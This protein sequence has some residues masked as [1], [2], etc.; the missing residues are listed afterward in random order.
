M[1]YTVDKLLA[2]MRDGMVTYSWCSLWLACMVTDENIDETMRKARS[3]ADEG[4]IT[5]L[6]CDSLLYVDSPV[7]GYSPKVLAGY[8]RIV[9]WFGKDGYKPTEIPVECRV[10]RFAS[11][12]GGRS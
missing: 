8:R 2:E 7:P 9:E 11:P 12:E 10:G 5:W 4:L 3:L 6:Y 1:A